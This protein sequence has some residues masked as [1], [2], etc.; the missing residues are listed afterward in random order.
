MAAARKWISL[1]VLFLAAIAGAIWGYARW[2]HNQV[3]VSTEN[4]YVRGHIYSVSSKIPGNLLTVEVEDNQAVKAGEVAATIDPRDYDAAVAKAEASLA[5]AQSALATD[6]AKIAQARAQVEAAGSQ[7]QLAKLE[8][9]RISALYARQ[10]LPKQRYDQAVSAEEVGEAQQAAAQKV[11][12]AQQASLEVSRKKIATA[13]A[14]L[15]QAKLQRSYCTITE[16]A[17]GVVSKKSAEPGMVVA[18][19]QPLFAVVPLDLKEIWVEANFKETQLRNVKPGQKVKLWADIDKR[20]VYSGTVESVAAGTGAVFS[21]LP[22]EN[23]T[24]NWVKVVQRVP[25]KVRLDEGE[26][27]EHSLRL[28]LTV[29]VEIDT[30]SK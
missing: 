25:V 15:D 12:A 7:L 3:Y 27:P 9:E 26:D 28:G 10:S 2:R 5:E 23:A 30:S 20:R 29:A 19:G 1:S 24:G 4:A 18:P 6:E 14:A 22:P 13:Q 17:D 8:K 21:L 11:V 16:P